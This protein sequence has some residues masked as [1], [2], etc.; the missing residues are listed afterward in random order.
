MS[1]EN[2][3]RGF[4]NTLKKTEL[5]NHCCELGIKGIWNCNKGQLVE[6]ILAKY[7]PQNES[8]LEPLDGESSETLPTLGKVMSEIKDI[9]EKL[10]MKEVEVED[11]Y[12]QLRITK[13]QLQLANESIYKL[14]E[15]VKTLQE[16]HQE[17]GNTGVYADR[18]NGTHNDD[19]SKTTLLIG[20]SNLRRIKSSDL[21]MD[22]KIRTINDATVNVLRSWIND[23]LD[24]VPRN[25]IIYC[26]VT[27]IINNA[28]PARML[29][30]FA[31][32]ISDLK[33]KRE[34]MNIYLCQLAP[35]VKDDDLQAR[36]NEFNDEL[37]KWSRTNN[38]NMIDVNTCFKLAN[39]KVDDMCYDFRE[40]NSSVLILNR[41]GVIMLLECMAHNWECF[42]LNSRWQEVK[43]LHNVANLVSNAVNN[44]CEV[45]K[46]E[47]PPLTHYGKRNIGKANRPRYRESG[48]LDRGYFHAT[49]NVRSFSNAVEQGNYFCSEHSNDNAPR[50]PIF[51]NRG[52]FNCG[53]INHR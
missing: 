45:Y 47:F 12:E 21:T 24:W 16:K 32:A 5:R 48:N 7:Q 8:T 40:G 44:I 30:N 27:D 35:S 26:G 20:D 50:E 43:R 37:E 28:T 29:D 13:E 17:A 53:E 23:Q 18:A 11:I 33:S 38:I 14:R 9:K 46:D 4:L 41:L 42:E 31:M 6:I 25:C 52:C 1:L 10:A 51:R 34:D 3:T 15:E 39:G 22:C 2:P 36:I 49:E 19:D